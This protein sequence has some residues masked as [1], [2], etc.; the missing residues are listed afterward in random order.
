MQALLAGGDQA[1]HDLGTVLLRL[2]YL[3]RDQLRA[4]LRSV[5]VDAMIALTVPL[6]GEAT[7]TAIR[8]EAPQAH[9]AAAFSQ[10]RVATVRAEARARAE[11]MGRCGAALTAPVTLYDRNAARPC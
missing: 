2:G 4:I 8:S 3:S 1:G 6:A 7:V 9:W 10:L 11:R 5:V